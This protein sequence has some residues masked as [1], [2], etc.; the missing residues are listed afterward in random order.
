MGR[1]LDTKDRKIGL[2]QLPM[3]F[4]SA[5]DA[6]RKADKLPLEQRQVVVKQVPGTLHG[7][8][9]ATHTDG[10]APILLIYPLNL[11]SYPTGATRWL[12]DAML[13][14]LPHLFD[15]KVTS[16]MLDR[17]IDRILDSAKGYQLTFYTLPN[18]PDVAHV[19]VTD[20]LDT[21]NYEFELH[22]DMLQELVQSCKDRV[23]RVPPPPL[24]RIA[25]LPSPRIVPLTVK[26]ALGWVY[27][28][29]ELDPRLYVSLKR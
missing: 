14:H 22:S 19:V 4:W 10:P 20:G 18:L 5:L 7:V 24:P 17:A 15:E 28:E 29:D 16:H 3:L 6:V 11:Y 13:H 2:P 1:R 21:W 27:I 8:G 9:F 25:Q 23:E 12:L 26:G